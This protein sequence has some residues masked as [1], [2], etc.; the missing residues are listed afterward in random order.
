[1]KTFKDNKDREWKVDVSVN[2]LR[3]V[4]D[5]I[6]LDLSGVRVAAVIEQL[7]NDLPLTVDVIYCIVKPQCDAAGVSDEDFGRA[8]QDEDG[9]IA[10]AAVVALMEG[11]IEFFPDARAR[12]VLS[13]LL[14]LTMRSKSEVTNG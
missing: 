13:R 1:M 3:R 5:L 8:L 6:G 14:E 7:S 9:S 10:S 2:S 4:R 11:L 12:K